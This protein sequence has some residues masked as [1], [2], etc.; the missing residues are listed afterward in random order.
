MT[1]EQILST[2]EPRSIKGII[3]LQ[4]WGEEVG[5]KGLQFFSEEYFNSGHILDAFTL[6]PNTH[7]APLPTNNS[8]W[9]VVLRM[10]RSL[11]LKSSFA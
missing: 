8:W 10:W 3:A 6:I 7:I 5:S 4:S 2:V 11:W 1:K 9:A